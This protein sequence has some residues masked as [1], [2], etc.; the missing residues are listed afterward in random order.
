MRVKMHQVTYFLALCDEQSFTRAARR[1]GIAQPSLTCAIQDLEGECGHR[2]FERNKS[3]V[4]LTELGM[5]LKSD[6]V[7]IEQA[8][9]NI[10]RKVAE[11]RHPPP[12][13][14]D[15]ETKEAPMRAVSVTVLAIMI[16]AV[17][18]ALRPTLLA[19]AAVTERTDSQIDPYALQSTIETKALPQQ[20]P[21]DLF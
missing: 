6:F 7:R 5:L 8:L 16:I 1:C 3:S 18:L 4:S 14:P 13:K 2:L 15:P 17:G 12:M 19:T 9:A 20:T 11:F 10:T 21:V